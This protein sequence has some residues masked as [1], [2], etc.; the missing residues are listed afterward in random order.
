MEPWKGQ[1]TST[2]KCVAISNPASQI[3]WYINGVLY[4]NTSPDLYTITD[5]TQVDEST[6]NA[7]VTSIFHV[8]SV[9]RDDLA[10]Y[11]CEA[12]NQVDGIER[13]DNRSTTLIISRTYDFLK[14]KREIY[15]FLAK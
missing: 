10:K 6:K 2:S 9:R 14:K 1:Q 13:S 12:V 7:E 5:T 3:K 15:R 4:Q 11:T 8:K